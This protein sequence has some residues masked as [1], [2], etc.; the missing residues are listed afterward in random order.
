MM[1]IGIDTE[2]HAIT[3]GELAPPIVCLTAAAAG[4][5]PWALPPPGEDVVVES[6]ARGWWAI[7]TGEAI[8]D[9]WA[10]F[11][12]EALAKRA[13]LIFQNAAFDLA[14]LAQHV[15]IRVYD[16]LDND[17]IADTMIREMLLAIAEARFEWDR[18]SGETK[19]AEYNLAALV[20]TYFGV[21]ISETKNDPDAWRLRYKELDGVPATKWPMAAISYALD[22][23]RWALSVY[24]AQAKPQYGG[25]NAVLVDENGVVTDEYNQMRNAWGLHCTGAWG[26][27]SDPDATAEWAHFVRQK[28]AEATEVA[29]M[30]GI[31][32]PLEHWRQ[33]NGGC[34]VCKQPGP[35]LD[36]RDANGVSKCPACGSPG[37]RSKNMAVFR[38]RVTAAYEKLGKEPP[39]TDGG[40]TGNKQVST[41]RDCLEQSGD[42]LLEQYA[43]LGTYMTY[44][45]TFVP[46]LERGSRKVMNPRWNILVETGR[47]SCAEP[48][49]TNPPR[50]GGF[51]ACFVP[52][53]GWYY[54]SVDYDMAELKAMG[55]IQLEWFGH[56]ALADALNAGLDPHLVLGADILAMKWGRPVTYAEI[57]AVPKDKNHP[58]YEAVHG[59]QGARQ[60]AKIGNFGFMGGL[61]AESFMDYART[62]YG[63]RL[64]KE[65]ATMIRQAWLNRWVEM[66]QYFAVISAAT[67]AIGEFTVLHLVSQ[68]QRGGCGYTQGC[69]SYFQGLIADTAKRALYE[70]WKAA[71]D[72]KSPCYGIRPVLFVHDEIIS[73]IPG[74]A[75]GWSPERTSAAADEQARIMKDVQKRYMPDM[76]PGASPAL[77]DRWHK[78][79]DSVRD[80]NGILQVWQPPVKK[81]A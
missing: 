60:L 4:A 70:V 34:R 27:V 44:L 77:M 43:A 30:A 69:N 58:N 18:R 12:Q 45:Q 63:V 73:E 40:K 79:V 51:R 8:A 76:A 59:A 21:D 78:G 74:E 22:D 39:L 71:H 61:G 68:R 14:V 29:S 35:F 72:P 33:K 48:N 38:A 46:I 6:D 56:S 24:I 20:R 25:A 3:P 17:C 49:L 80:A 10:W 65:D 32:R 66:A 81:A 13:L 42:D 16:L 55:Q 26:V 28:A 2:T 64:T 7:Y 52:R 54:C 75:L 19:R 11:E 67:E 53:P 9:A 47:I 37:K 57:K 31:L 5:Y 36:F 15:G 62:G 1:L 50:A 41:D 23:A